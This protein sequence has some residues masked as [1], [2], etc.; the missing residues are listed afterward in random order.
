LT[1][2]KCSTNRCASCANFISRAARR[3]TVW[4][5]WCR[6]W[7]SARHSWDP[8]IQVARGNC[9]WKIAC[10]KYFFV[11]TVWLKA[12]KKTSEFSQV[13]KHLSLHHLPVDLGMP[14]LE[15]QLSQHQSRWWLITICA[16]EKSHCFL[17]KLHLSPK[18]TN[19]TIYIILH[20]HLRNVVCLSPE[21]CLRSLEVTISNPCHHHLMGYW[22]RESHAKNSPC[23]LKKIPFHLGEQASMNNNWMKL[24]R[25]TH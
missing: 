4:G 8:G 20:L 12:A 22:R 17:L 7:A 24:P 2:T 9:G 21:A 3:C 5:S 13:P 15:T 19:N 16:A 6:F 18:A 11:A 10:G 25:L 23:L 14:K 1:T